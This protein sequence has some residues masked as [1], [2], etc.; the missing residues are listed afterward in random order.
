MGMLQLPDYRFYDGFEGEG[1]L[2]LDLDGNKEE[3][4]HIWEGYLSDVLHDPD[5]SGNGWTGFMRDWQQGER[6]LDSYRQN[7]PIEDL[8]EYIEDWKQYANIEFSAPISKEC[9]EFILAFMEYAK[10][11]GRT[12]TVTYW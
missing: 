4:I 6:T 5:M 9:Y 10:R 2:E 8:D 7:V 3:S 12:V 1:E 11:E